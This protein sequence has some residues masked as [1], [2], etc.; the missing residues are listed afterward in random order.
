MFQPSIELVLIIQGCYCSIPF[1]EKI[2]QSKSCV[3]YVYIDHW[4]F[5]SP[6]LDL[7][8]YPCFFSLRADSGMFCGKSGAI[9][10]SC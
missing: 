4:V 9:Y 7:S 8:I 5:P 1:L 6:S 2:S 3:R 10:Y